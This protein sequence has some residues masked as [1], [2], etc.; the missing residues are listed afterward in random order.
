MYPIPEGAK[1]DPGPC[2]KCGGNGPV[3]HVRSKT[4]RNWWDEWQ[5]CMACVAPIA[6]ATQIQ[7]ESGAYELFLPGGPD[8]H[9]RRRGKNPDG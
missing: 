1:T 2:P 4:D 6:F 5:G 8:P 3:M 7:D 9:A